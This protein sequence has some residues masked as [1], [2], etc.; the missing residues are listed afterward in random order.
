MQG[1]RTLPRPLSL[2]LLIGL[3]LVAWVNVGLSI[4]VM[5]TGTPADWGTFVAITQ[6]GSPFDV[7]LWRW[8]PVAAVLFEWIV[9]MGLVVW[10]ALHIAAVFLIPDWRWRIGL[11]IAWP[12]WWD[13]IAGNVMIFVVVAAYW[14]L[15]RHPAG[16]IATLILAL[17]IPRPFM[18]PLVMWILWT[19]RRW[20]LPF[21]GLFA[22]HALAV[23]QTGFGGEWIS[24][25][26][27]SGAELTHPENIAPSAIFGW[28]WVLG[29]LPL[30]V[31][32]YLRGWIGLSAVL[33]QPYWF[34]YYLLLAPLRPATHPQESTP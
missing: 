1:V 2:P 11:L 13:V 26:V 10:R 17:L 12:L 4:R 21:A 14:A 28:W 9:P 32:A 7:P 20:I 25:L 34:P 22:I 31:W 15:R 24:R 8:S 3:A 18:V 27:S 16:I 6:A 5:L 30:A 33:V 29:A 19:D 23:W